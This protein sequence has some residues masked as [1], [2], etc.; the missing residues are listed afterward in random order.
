MK[1]ESQDQSNNNSMQKPAINSIPLSRRSGK[2]MDVARSKGI[3]HF[4]T[5]LTNT[6]NP[7]NKIPQNTDIK[8]VRH[9]LAVKTDQIRR[10]LATVPS[11]LIAAKSLKETKE[12]AIN[13]ALAKPAST[14]KKIGFFKRHIKF[15]NIFSIS[16]VL[17]II[18]GAV[19]YLYMPSISIRIAG[20][21]AGINAT[22][23]SYHPDGYS[24]NGPVT[25]N[26]GE[27][28]I[29]F[30]ANTGST[31]FSINQFKSSWDSSAVRNKINKDSNG[32]FITT[33]EKGLTIYTYKG[34]AAWVNG[35]ILYTINGNAPLSGDQIR[36]I[37]TSL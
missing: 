27:V 16:L 20:S 12:D 11:K 29:N 31:G 1:N 3:K 18:I 28:T 37:A 34:N 9:P 36:R 32:E 25:Y 24:V 17:L 4:A 6:N 21:Q 14:P 26:N 7:S 5:T 22:F 23:P 2:T 15:I 8:H 33:A 13:E 30:K 19:V 35:G 10:S